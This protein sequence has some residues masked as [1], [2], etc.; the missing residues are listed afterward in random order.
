MSNLASWVHVHDFEH[1][2][3]LDR[4]PECSGKKSIQ[5]PDITQL[6]SMYSI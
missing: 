2:F 3:N 6:Y 4:G 5:K 1:Y